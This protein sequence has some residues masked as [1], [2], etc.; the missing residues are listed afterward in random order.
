MSRLETLA[1]R[2]NL[3]PVLEFVRQSGSL[4]GEKAALVELL[5]EE[6]FLNVVRHAYA[7]EHG[8]LIITCHWTQS[9]LLQLRFEDQGI[10]FNPLLAEDPQLDVPLSER[11]IGGLGI[12]LVKS[13]ARA[14]H[15]QRHNGWN[16]FSFEIPL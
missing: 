11:R 14:L 1:T 6:V 4:T 13:L 16:I 9:A 2:S 12:V 10:E 7:E 8:P 5:V 3:A 15:Y